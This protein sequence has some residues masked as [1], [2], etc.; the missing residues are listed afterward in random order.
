MHAKVAALVKHLQA[1]H[2]K[3]DRY[4]QKRL[5][6][7]F[8]LIIICYF[9]YLFFRYRGPSDVARLGEILGRASILICTECGAAIHVLDAE[10]HSV[11]CRATPRFPLPSQVGYHS[12]SQQQQSLAITYPSPSPITTAPVDVDKTT[13][14]ISKQKRKYKRRMKAELPENE[15]LQPKIEINSDIED[16]I[17]KSPA[18]TFEPPVEPK[19]EPKDGMEFR[20]PGEVPIKKKVKVMIPNLDSPRGLRTLLPG[21]Q[22]FAF[23]IIS[24][25]FVDKFI[26]ICREQRSASDTS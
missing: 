7:S 11:N 1:V 23:I 13:P 17:M 19:V 18:Q 14:N 24:L 3:E 25:I 5:N 26:V 16:S 21:I 2:G 22:S 8:H 20:S 4:L 10:A 9:V 6:S 15:P 12:D